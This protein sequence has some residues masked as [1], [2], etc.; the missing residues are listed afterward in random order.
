MTIKTVFK[1]EHE[2]FR[3]DGDGQQAANAIRK[4]FPKAHIVLHSFEI[5]SSEGQKTIILPEIY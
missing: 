4:D 1:I 3:V 5:T 2:F